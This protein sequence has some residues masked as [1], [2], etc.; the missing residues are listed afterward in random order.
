MS[1]GRRK[2]PSTVEGRRRTVELGKIISSPRTC[3]ADRLEALRELDMI[4]PLPGGTTAPPQ[5]ILSELPPTKPSNA[6]LQDLCT[7][8]ETGRKSEGS[9][10]EKSILVAEGPTNLEAFL[11][12]MVPDREGVLRRARNAS[13]VE[14]AA[15]LLEE[16]PE[17]PLCKLAQEMA[18]WM[19]QED[20]SRPKPDASQ[21]ALWTVR[22]WL[23]KQSYNKS[24]IRGNVETV[25]KEVED[26]YRLL[27]ERDAAE[28]DWYVRRA[29]KFFDATAP[30]AKPELPVVSDTEPEAK[31]PEKKP[32]P[33]SMAQRTEADLERN[34]R[35]IVE[36]I[37]ANFLGKLSRH[38][39]EFDS[40]IK[41]SVA[42]RLQEYGSCDACF[43]AGLY[44][45]QRPR[46][47]SQFPPRTF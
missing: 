8:V 47:S 27:A 24:D 2:K 14:R 38:S 43:L 34:V 11:C 20:K 12:H 15:V 21:I 1:T 39:P 35:L 3:K 5:S 18:A 33:A 41:A 22:G 37:D 7:R 32:E 45:A 30:M 13:N 42:R 16:L 44:N 19:W 17:H 9:L 10:S 31:P 23:T 46:N 4:A 28:P 6:D 29:E 25:A 26:A 36:V 40:A